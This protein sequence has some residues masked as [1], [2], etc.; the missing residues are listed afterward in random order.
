MGPKRVLVKLC[1][2]CGDDEAGKEDLS[3]VRLRV[4]LESLKY[5]R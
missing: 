4:L 5:L 2:P 3:A 1:I